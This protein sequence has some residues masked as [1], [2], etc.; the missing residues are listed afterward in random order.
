MNVADK[1]T[2]RL[3]SRRCIG[4]VFLPV[5]FVAAVAPL[6]AQHFDAL[7]IKPDVLIKTV[8]KTRIAGTITRVDSRGVYMIVPDGDKT[9]QTDSKTTRGSSK[10][11][12]SIS[13]ARQGRGNTG[14][15][16]D[17]TKRGA[18]Q[19][20]FFS[21]PTYSIVFRDGVTNAD[22]LLA[23]G[24]TFA[25][26][27]DRVFED[28]L[29]NGF[30]PN[31]EKDLARNQARVEKLLR[32]IK[33]EA[34]KEYGPAQEMLSNYTSGAV[35]SKIKEARALRDVLIE[36]KTHCGIL[37]KTLCRGRY[38]SVKE[39][40]EMVARELTKAIKRVDSLSR[41]GEIEDRVK[42]AL[43]HVESIADDL[44]A[45][46]SPGKLEETAPTSLAGLLTQIKTLAIRI[47]QGNDLS[48]LGADMNGWL[49]QQKDAL[50]KRHDSVRQYIEQ[51]RELVALQTVLTTLAEDRA[52]E[53]ELVQPRFAQSLA[54][55]DQFDQ[56][57][58]SISDESARAYARR[59]AAR[60][61]AQ[62]NVAKTDRRLA[63]QERAIKEQANA[64]ASIDTAARAVAQYAAMSDRR[65]ELRRMSKEK[66]APRQ[67]ASLE[68]STRRLLVGMVACKGREIDL[69]VAQLDRKLQEQLSCSEGSELARRIECVDEVLE[70]QKSVEKK[71][72]EA[73]AELPPF[74]TESRRGLENCKDICFQAQQARIL[75]SA[76]ADVKRIPRDI[77]GEEEHEE[78]RQLVAEATR[79]MEEFTGQQL[80]RL[81]DLRER[82]TTALELARKQARAAVPVIRFREALVDSRARLSRMESALDADDFEEGRQAFSL[83]V[84]SLR[85]MKLLSESDESRRETVRT[86]E[87]RCNRHRQEFNKR[88]REARLAANWFPLP[89]AGQPLVAPGAESEF[90]QIELLLGDLRLAEAAD[91]IDAF[92]KM[93]GNSR[94]SSRLAELQMRLKFLGAT[95]EEEQGQLDEA[96]AHYQNVASAAT[97]HALPSAAR[98]A[99]VRVKS[100]LQHR[101]ESQRN[102]RRLVVIGA[103][104]LIGAG[105]GAVF[106]WLNTESARLHRAERQL[107][108]AEA[109][110]ARGDAQ[111]RDAHFAQVAQT[112]SSFPE[113]HGLA[114]RLRERLAQ[115]ISQQS[116]RPT[117]E[118]AV[119]EVD[120][121]A[122]IDHILATSAAAREA[123]AV[124]LDYVESQRSQQSPERRQA[125]FAWMCEHLVP[126]RSLSAD[127]LRWRVDAVRRCREAGGEQDRTFLYEL[128]LRWWLGQFDESAKLATRID[129][130]RLDTG[131]NSDLYVPLACCYLRLGQLDEANALLKR[132]E[133]IPAVAD[134]ATHWRLVVT[135]QMDANRRGIRSA[136]QIA[137]LLGE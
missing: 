80:V 51:T 83:V 77:D 42:T 34:D 90:L 7:R 44:D 107:N 93:R 61:R 40:C 16:S 31:G 9:K 105:S 111:A 98:S 133:A 43:N 120:M 125:V 38:D 95:V 13:R 84:G 115:P 66:L 96:C 86:C 128:C 18:G 11:R 70:E 137:A 60:L 127:E 78:S 26:D 8:G 110:A 124:C 2:C 104:L 122:V 57:T 116:G 69:R 119:A 87:G 82:V 126:E 39:H 33:P 5:I 99:M 135:T 41:A 23:A 55:L 97:D 64:V 30:P 15:D 102:S 114:S 106:F 52:G 45:L 32:R 35:E 17:K 88:L 65:E 103:V 28:C 19:P 10:T 134:E 129:T 20:K 72:R 94:W 79:K 136:K 68:A 3:L 130:G 67:L 92:E 46:P 62:F 53:P 50:S 109:S 36:T 12:Q 76:F 47:D 75:L 25:E 71:W 1:A 58:A 132:L 37:H 21:F 27:I 85:T 49:L 29:E 4:V 100:Q 131:R 117:G 59:H 24:R 48:V 6:K 123:I 101:G 91:R 118:L 22:K 113:D 121:G 14:Q 74:Q 81:K 63:M 108:A 54:A 73:A 89:I 56:K 112:L